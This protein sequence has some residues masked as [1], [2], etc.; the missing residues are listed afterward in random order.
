MAS[1]SLL[2][3]A[4]FSELLALYSTYSLSHHHVN[5]HVSKHRLLVKAA[6]ELYGA[7]AQTVLKLASVAKMHD[8]ISEV[9]LCWLRCVVRQ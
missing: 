8:L 1:D 9:L 5:E 7:S 2:I 6:W 3:L 4:L